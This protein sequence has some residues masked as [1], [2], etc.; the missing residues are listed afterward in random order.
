MEEG[1]LTIVEMLQLS[2]VQ[3]MQLTIGRSMTLLAQGD[4]DVGKHVTAVIV[5]LTCSTSI[6]RQQR[7]HCRCLR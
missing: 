2:D 1:R 5:T 4:I 7:M 6:H 3:Q